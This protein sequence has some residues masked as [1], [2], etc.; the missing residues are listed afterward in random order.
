MIFMRSVC[1]EA[2]QQQ[3]TGSSSVHFLRL[4]SRKQTQH[5]HL[6]PLEQKSVVFADFHRD[7]HHTTRTKPLLGF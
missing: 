6:P 3:P 4:I 7:R 1:S 5:L 2:I